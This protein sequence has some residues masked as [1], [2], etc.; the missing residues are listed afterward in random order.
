M[1]RLKPA[2]IFLLICS[3]GL[4]LSAC[5]QQS[6]RATPKQQHQ[7]DAGADVMKQLKEQPIREFPNT[8]L[9]AEDIATLVDF[10]E[11]FAQ[12]SDEMEAELMKMQKDGTLTAEFD[13]NRK[14]DNIQS[15]LT[16][17]KQLEL[18]TEQGRYIQGLLYQYWEKQAVAL[19]SQDSQNQQSTLNSLAEYVQAHKQLQHWKLN[20]VKK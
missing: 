18:K 14:R 13:F 12:M 1:L 6:E 16:M 19:D 8:P 17:L 9:D 3:S 2:V 4:I 20:Q 11:R 7:A 5:E 15:A 10:D